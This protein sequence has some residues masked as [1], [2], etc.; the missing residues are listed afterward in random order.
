MVN[1]LYP[2]FLGNEAEYRAAEEYWC[3]L[4]NSVLLSAGEEG[5][6]KTPWLNSVCV[7]GTVLRTGDP[8]FSAWNPERRL[9]VRIVQHEPRTQEID[10]DVELTLFDEEVQ[11]IR[12]LVIFCVFSEV[13][14]QQAFDLLIQF[15]RTGTIGWAREHWTSLAPVPTQHTFSP[16][17]ISLRHAECVPT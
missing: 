16:P 8:I 5:A 13:T 14:A 7:D 12:V 6:W 2:T 1:H 9:A 4:W 10:L 3:D 17:Y 11:N 15:V